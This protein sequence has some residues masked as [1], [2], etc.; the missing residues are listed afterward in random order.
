MHAWPGFLL[1]SW[2]AA[3]LLSHVVVL[4]KASR[5]KTAARRRTRN[6]E[7]NGRACVLLLQITRI[8]ML[9]LASMRLQV[10]SLQAC[11]PPPSDLVV[12]CSPQNALA[13]VKAI[14]SPSSGGAEGLKLVE[15]AKAAVSAVKVAQALDAI[16]GL[17]DKAGAAK[18]PGGDGQ[19]A[20][21]RSA[22]T[23]SNLSAYLTLYK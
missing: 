13:A 11:T 16:A 20:A 2:C 9:A 6:A 3:R 15:K 21:L 12:L 19:G 17:L 5:V 23:L 4:L 10:H 22:D 7:T 14:A 8:C 18:V 1:Q